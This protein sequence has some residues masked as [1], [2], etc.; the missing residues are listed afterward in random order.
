MSDFTKESIWNF[1]ECF[2][3]GAGKTI[4]LILVT[5]LITVTTCTTLLFLYTIAEA[6]VK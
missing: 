2:R 3:K 4:D 6:V 1:L 5:I